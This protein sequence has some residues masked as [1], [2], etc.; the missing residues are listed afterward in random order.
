MCIQFSTFE[1][2]MRLMNISCLILCVLLF[3]VKIKRKMFTE[4]C[5]RRKLFFTE[6]LKEKKLID[7]Y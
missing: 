3:Q 6:K 1:Y 7:Y 4:K 2:H 5:R